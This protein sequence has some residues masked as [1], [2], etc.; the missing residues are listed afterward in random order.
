MP[1]NTL[2]KYIL[3][4]LIIFLFLPYIATYSNNSKQTSQEKLNN[5]T[6]YANKIMA[7][8]H[9][10]GMSIAIVENDKI[11]YAKGFGKRNE[12]GELVT[13]DT[14]FD[15]ASLTK[16]FTAALIA[17]QIDQ[18]K[19]RWDTKVLRLFPDFKLY[20]T[21]ATQEFAV[22]DLI[23]HHS[24]LPE[25]ALDAL[26]NFGYST[27]HTLY[28]LRF[29]QPVTPF[30][31]AFAYQD[32]FLEIAKKIIEK[33]SGTSYAENLHQLIFQP[34]NMNHSYVRTEAALNKNNNFAQPFAY[35]AGKIDPYPSNYPY[36]SAKWALQIGVAGGGIQSSAIDIAKWLIFNMNNGI[37]NNHSLITASNMRFIHSPQTIISLN[38]S[39]GEG[40]Y[41]DKKEYQPYT[42]LYHSGGGTGMHA[43]MAYIPEK[44]LGIVILTNTYNNKIPEIL[45]KKFFDLFLNR[46]YDKNWNQIYLHEKT[47]NIT[48]Q[49]KLART[50]YCPINKKTNLKR[51][52]G[53]Y[54]NPVYGKLLMSQQVDHLVLTIGP[55]RITW[56][57][58]PCNDQVFKANWSNPGGMDFPMLPLS[59]D[60]VE[61]SADI[62]H[63]IQQ[64]TIPFLNND[65]TGVF[66][67]I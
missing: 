49:T 42:L 26:G 58:I 57:L 50:N 2:K 41:I 5:F 30:K 44:K 67:K 52:I 51:Y 35:Y 65:G 20:N 32:V 25:E 22:K 31:T 17:S 37:V 48:S 6:D 11:I 33:Y 4:I 53:I 19:Y 8:W 60:N 40:W 18:G 27:D 45:S 16:S 64:M 15:I 59:Q 3:N 21:K 13:P 14:L 39:Y 7:D 47:K 29:V 66:E 56:T 54:Y 1:M 24:G 62:H 63:T 28:A 61:F 55:Q 38:N 43:L 12:Q 23:A 36:L 9:V 46:K 34:L 10:P